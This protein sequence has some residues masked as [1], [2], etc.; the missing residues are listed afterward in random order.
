MRGGPGDYAG[1]EEIDRRKGVDVGALRRLLPLFRPHM[2]LFLFSGL[3]MAGTSLLSLAGPMLLKRAI[4]RDIPSGDSRGLAV[5]LA[6][7]VAAQF[8]V[9]AGGT[10]TPS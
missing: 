9:H 5:T 6:M 3:L 1:F 10:H 4:D 2:K 7:F 8:L